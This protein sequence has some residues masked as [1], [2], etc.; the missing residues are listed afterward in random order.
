MGK[1]PVKGAHGTYNL[2][3]ISPNGDLNVQALD[4][5]LDWDPEL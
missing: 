5:P 4:V 3:R 2:L 1:P